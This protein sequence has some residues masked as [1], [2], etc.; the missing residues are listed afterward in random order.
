M[1]KLLLVLGVVAVIAAAAL[2]FLL[3]NIDT[4]VKGGIEKYGSKATGT[5]VGV[6][7]VK[8]RLKEGEGSIRGFSIDNPRGFSG[9]RAFDLEG[10]SVKIDTASVTKDPI[11]IESVAV[12]APRVLYEINES[13]KGNF[14]A[15][16]ENLGASGS[17]EK[18]P[19]KEDSGKEK[20][21]VIRNLV[22]E[23]GNVEIRVAALGE[24]P[25]SA[26]LPSIRLTNLGG[27]GGSTPGEI[28]R[29]ILGPLTQRVVD[30]ALKAGVGQY[31]GKSAEDV[32][33]MAEEAAKEKLGTIGEDA[34]KEAEGA[35][36]K[37]LG[38]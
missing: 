24:K 6:S 17:G 5:R 2:F 19:A 37:L 25:I 26:A 30:E 16:K 27:K 11:V 38:K 22:I 13:G 20:K 12:S 4:I 21:I 31:L 34:A 15:I 3:S 28:A 29:Q 32:K 14:D 9:N 10:I 7:S 18:P 23:K 8:L 1:K 35:L 33:K 36:K